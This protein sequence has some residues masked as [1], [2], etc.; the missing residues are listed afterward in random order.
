MTGA[1]PVTGVLRIVV[2]VRRAA[3]ASLVA[4]VKSLGE[5]VALCVAADAEARPVLAAARAAGASRLVRVWDPALETTDY[6]GIAYALAAAV[7]AIGD[8]AASPMLIVA[9]DRGRGAVGPAVAERLGVPLIGQ[10]LAVELRD[11]KV[12]ARRRA[13]DV[14]RS[15][16]SAL[17]A[18]VCVIVD[19]AA[20]FAVG[21][22][23][24]IESWT[25]SKVG[26]S[27]A[28]L[29]YRKHFRPLPTKGPVPSPR[30]LEDAAALA[31]RLRADG[32]LRGDG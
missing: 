29:G 12:V 32:L 22:A 10:V 25:L 5:V 28:E 30:K 6:L 31:A 23:G 15:Y 8:P 14:V 20:A 3:D 1:A 13:R 19:P 24:E 7:R 17:P 26:L 21:E 9:G 27:G 11:G 18:L 2:L 4:A 16:G